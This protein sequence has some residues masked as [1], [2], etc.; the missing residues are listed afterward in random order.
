MD[1]FEY[2]DGSVTPPEQTL[3]LNGSC[4]MPANRLQLGTNTEWQDCNSFEG[5]LT[6]N[7]GC[8]VSMD[9]DPDL[10][11]ARFNKLANKEKGGAWFVMERTKDHIA[12]WAWPPGKAPAQLLQLDQSK[13]S[14]HHPHGHSHG[15]EEDDEILDTSLFGTPASYFPSSPSS[16][17]LSE[18]FDLLHPII[19][20]NFGGMGE[21][22]WNVSNCQTLAPSS[23][24]GWALS[25]NST[26][27]FKETKGVSVEMHIKSWNVWL[28]LED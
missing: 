16:C 11:P 10:I 20:L 9:Q 13:K 2:G 12:G 19:N 5:W 7:H 3:H 27:Y 4:P 24:G 18:K 22:F 26:K 1:I 15:H 8:G 21:L 28:S 17:D 6:G 14:S 23:Y 25:E